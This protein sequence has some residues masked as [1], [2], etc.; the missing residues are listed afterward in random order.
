MPPEYNPNEWPLEK[1]SVKEAWL[2]IPTNAEGKIKGEGI[3]IAHP[4]TGWTLHPELIN[5]NRYLTGY[6]LS[7][8][9]FGSLSEYQIAE[10]DLSGLHPSHGTTTASLMLSEENHPSRNNPNKYPNYNVPLSEYVTGIAPKVEV[11]PLRVTNFVVLGVARIGTKSINTYASLS[12]AIYYALSLRTDSVGVISIS[13]GGLGSPNNLQQAL[14]KARQKGVIV[15]A[16][17]GQV[18]S[19]YAKDLSILKGPAFPSTSIHTIS[20]AGCDSNF[21]TKMKD[22]EDR[23][24]N[25]GFYGYQV[26]ITTPGYGVKVAETK[27]TNDPYTIITSNGTSYSTAL[28][29]GACALWQAYHGRVNL[30]KRFGRPLILD[31]FRVCMAESSWIPRGQRGFNSDPDYKGVIS[32]GFLRHDNRGNGVLDVEKLLEYPL[33]TFEYTKKVADKN[34]WPEAEWGDPSNWGRE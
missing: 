24:F 26:E 18:P 25:I 8:N 12:K 30:I 31:A 6:P 11:L 21:E 27:D 34:Q 22:E 4:D 2:K 7:K 14:K 1:C 10:D 28:T 15:I 29:S 17:A 13:L 32:D 23:I 9:F 33:P 19:Y 16:A 3:I 20:V 5:G